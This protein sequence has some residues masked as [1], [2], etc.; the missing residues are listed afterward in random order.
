MIFGDVGRNKLR[1]R[2]HDAV[3]QVLGQV[4]PTRELDYTLKSLIAHH[5]TMSGEARTALTISLSILS[6]PSAGGRPAWDGTRST[7]GFLACA[8]IELTAPGAADMMI[9]SVVLVELSCRKTATRS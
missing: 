1:Q 9:V 3:L 5:G 6:R 7:F 8:R 4:R 2:R